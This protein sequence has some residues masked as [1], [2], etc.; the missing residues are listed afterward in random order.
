M[1]LTNLELC[2]I[3]F[4]MIFHQHNCRRVQFILS[5]S[6]HPELHQSLL[7]LLED[8]EA[9]AAAQA[10]FKV[11][12]VLVSSS[13]IRPFLDLFPLWLSRSSSSPQRGR[14]VALTTSLLGCDTPVAGY[15]DHLYCNVS[16][17]YQTSIFESK[18]EETH[19]A[20]TVKMSIFRALVTIASEKEKLIVN[21]ARIPK[22]PG[23]LLTV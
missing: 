14:W 16:F 15:K 11:A 10:I 6:I 20:V 9:I 5:F 2:R 4:L 23:T 22:R 3:D 7:K 12:Y 17:Y 18:V 21:A 19:I 8:P 13:N 1:I